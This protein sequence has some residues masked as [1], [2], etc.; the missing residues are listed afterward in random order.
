MSGKALILL[1]SF[2]IH[3][4][5]FSTTS[6]ECSDN[7]D[8]GKCEVGGALVASAVSAQA[9]LKLTV[10]LRAMNLGRQGLQVGG[11]TSGKFSIFI[12]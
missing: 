1:K 6:H 12:S 3:R 7:S 10:Q 11:S 5:L 4:S 8:T 9:S 2:G